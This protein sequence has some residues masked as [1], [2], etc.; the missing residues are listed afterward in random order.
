MPNHRTGCAALRHTT[1]G[2]RAP[3]QSRP[4]DH[5]QGQRMAIHGKIQ[6]MHEPSW[7]ARIL[8]ARR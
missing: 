7:L 3:W 8:G 4:S 1:A 6:P 5:L 2:N